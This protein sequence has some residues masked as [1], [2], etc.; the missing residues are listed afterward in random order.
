[1]K[2]TNRKVWVI[3]FPRSGNT[4]LRNIL[5]F[6]HKLA[7]STYAFKEGG[8]LL[9]E[10]YHS[11]PVIKSHQ[12]PHEIDSIKQDDFIIYILRDPRDALISIAHHKKDIVHPGTDFFHNLQEA[13]IAAE[14]SYFGGWSNNANSWLDRANMVIR[15]ED[16]IS[17]SELILKNIE[18]E[19]NLNPGN[20]NLVPAFSELKE[21]AGQYTDDL[22]PNNSNWANH[23]N[24]FF[25]KGKAGGWKDEFPAELLPL[26]YSIHGKTMERLGYHKTGDT[27]TKSAFDERLKLL[28][29]AP[30]PIKYKVLIEASK[31]SDKYSDGV[32]RYIY[33]LTKGIKS[34]QQFERDSFEFDLYIKGVVHPLIQAKE[35]EKKEDLKLNH[36][37][38]LAQVY[39]NI[40]SWIKTTLPK[41][42]STLLVGTYRQLNAGELIN[43][44]L[45]KYLDLYFLFARRKMKA[46]SNN[47]DLIHVSLPQNISIF[48]SAKKPIV[49]TV[50]DL[51]HKIY[52]DYHKKENVIK[53][54][55][56]I[57][58]SKEIKSHYISVSRNTQ[59]DFE[60]YYKI[61][62]A[63][64]T[65]IY[66]AAD[67][68]RFRLEKRKHL[69]E[70]A[71]RKYNISETPY[72]LCLFTLEPRKNL[73]NTIKAFIQYIDSNPENKFQLI[74]AGQTGWKYKP[75]D[76]NHPLVKFIGYVDE[77][78]LTPIY[79]QAHA[80]CYI[81][82]YEGFGLPLLESIRC[83]TPVIYGD[84]SSMKE[85]IGDCGLAVDSSSITDI[86]KG[87]AEMSNSTV[88]SEYIVRSNKLNE[89]FTW[90]N[91]AR[92]TIA[93]Y[94]KIIEKNQNS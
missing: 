18:H 15:Y 43:R 19:L 58:L 34:L 92:D 46:I 52:P 56:G 38:R 54:E 83:G 63:T 59:K 37:E 93:L 67:H 20:I 49:T 71:R 78:D 73:D 3:S 11:F 40:K 44:I 89:N 66:E 75:Q 32:K 82:H 70:K 14:G 12:L 17:N 76:W 64:I 94:R 57:Q 7:S 69:L 25:R 80:L 55:K 42:I 41:P 6:T 91:T 77:A 84:N 1:M 35:Q 88:R 60:K 85:I 23:A 74:I 39:Q 62:S 31:L 79:A 8:S 48:K 5:Y 27:I 87:I 36:L 10:D 16:L 50:H 21:G 30:K 61:P 29:S 22:D 4:F 86:S 26:L 45:A 47:Y 81:S 90:L 51:T 33:G 24:K 65:T 13:I 9:F 2:G 72:Y 28:P 68:E 53:S